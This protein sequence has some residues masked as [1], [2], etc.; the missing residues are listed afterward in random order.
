MELVSLIKVAELSMKL[1]LMNNLKII[2]ELGSLM[3]NVK[4]VLIRLVIRTLP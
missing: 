3:I 1:G 2:I 4:T